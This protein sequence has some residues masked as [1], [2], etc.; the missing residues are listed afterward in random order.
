M[1]TPTPSRKK[2][3]KHLIGALVA[4]IGGLILLNQFMAQLAPDATAEHQDGLQQ[5]N[6]R[7]PSRH[8]PQHIVET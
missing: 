7:T 1:N 8:S 4:G 6:H 5:I 2:S 3:V